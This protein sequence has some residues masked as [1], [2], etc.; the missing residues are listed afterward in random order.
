MK[1]ITLNVAFFG[2][3]LAVSAG[4]YA[5]N[6]K[7][8]FNDLI[9]GGN[10][11][12]FS[13]RE[14]KNMISHPVVRRYIEQK[15]NNVVNIEKEISS[16]P[17]SD[18][19]T[20]LPR[21]SQPEISEFE[22]LLV[23]AY[24]DDS[25]DVILAKFLAI[26]HFSQTRGWRNVSGETVK[27]LIYAEYFLNRVQNLGASRPWT[28]ALLRRVVRKIDRIADSDDDIDLTENHLAHAGFLEAFNYNEGNR[29]EVVD[30]LFEDFIVNPN[31]IVTNA[32]LTASNIWVG[33]EADYEDPTVLYSFIL[34]AYFSV[35]TVSMA[36]G[37]QSAWVENPEENQRFR[38]APIL[39][40]WT[41]PARRWLAILHNDSAA[42]AILDDEHREW[43]GVNAAFHSAS[44]GLMFFDEEENFLEGLM[45]WNA[46][47]EHCREVADLR[48]CP[49]RP[50]F[51]FNI[52]SFLLG[53]VDYLLKLG[54]KGTASFMLSFRYAPFLQFD[55]WTL[56]QEAWLHR[57]QNLDAIVELYQNDDLTDDPAHF[58]LKTRKWG[59]STITCQ[60]CHQ[61]QNRFWTEEEKAEVWMPSED[62]W[63]VPSWPAVTTSWHGAVN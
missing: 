25:S 7:H 43:L 46:G 37:L 39:G 61:V 57:E 54:D 52:L 40:G 10:D 20:H 48:S 47:N 31:N 23:S 16:N 55:N 21:N 49:D 32:Y 2:L 18:Y 62:V 26:Y 41:V 8:I 3:L 14:K 12:S 22:K 29:Y 63:A 6:D 35:R 28:R 11:I 50:R 5:K 42:V 15:K 1:Y 34:S 60:T 58:G 9:G 59:P 44:V 33:G 36:Q 51:S 56:G 45:A 13:K 19:E 30:S 24:L 4:T 38:L 27:H 53:Q 17:L